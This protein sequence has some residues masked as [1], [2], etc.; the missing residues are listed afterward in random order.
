MHYIVV[1]ERE[2]GSF[3]HF[4]KQYRNIVS[5]R[6]LLDSSVGLKAPGESTGTCQYCYGCRRLSGWYVQQLMKLSAPEVCDSETLIL[7]DSDFVFVRN[8]D[9]YAL[10]DEQ[11]LPLFRHDDKGATYSRYPAW[12]ENANRLIGLSDDRAARYNYVTAP[13]YW[14]RSCVV[15]L[16]EHIERTTGLP[17]Q[18]ALLDS[19]QFSE[20]TLY[21]MYVQNR[22]EQQRLHR[23]TD[24]WK[25]RLKYSF[26][27]NSPDGVA[28]YLEGLAPGIYGV[29]IERTCG[30]RVDEYRPAIEHMW[31]SL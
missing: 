1:D 22:R 30:M 20:Y 21:A 29:A 18:R 17:W 5:S 4:Q 25:T 16:R 3:K 24:D 15:A 31:N 26:S 10:L 27:P 19:G 11:C 8:V 6:E 9:L 23:F 7:M 12:Y 28:R 2:L 13:I 14:Y